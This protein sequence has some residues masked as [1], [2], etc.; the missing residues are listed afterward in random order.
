MNRDDGTGVDRR[1]MGAQY[2]LY[3]GVMGI[4]LPYFNLYCFHLGFS[5]L[6]IGILSATRS[7]MMILFPVFWGTLADRFQV[8]KPLYILLNFVSTAIWAALLLTTGF[9]GIL[10]TMIAYGIFYS[11]LIAFME[12]FTMEV[13]G[14]EKKR[15][16]MVRAWG[17]LAFIGVAT[18]LGRL[19]DIWSVDIIIGL[20]LAGSAVQA[21]VAL[22]IPRV[23]RHQESRFGSDTRFLRERGMCLFLFCAFLMLVSHG[24]YY[25]FLSIH[26]ESLGY[27]K[28]FIGIAWALASAAEIVVMVGSDKIFR[29]VSPENALFFAFMMATLRWLILFLATSPAM[30]LVSQMFHA[31]TYAVFHIASI[32]YVDRMTPRAA[33]T[34]GQAVN[35]ALTYGLGMT[36]G[37]FL[38]G[39]LYESLGAFRLFFISSLIA[40]GGGILFWYGQRYQARHI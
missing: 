16:G 38:N 8:R 3:F 40:L 19:I 30:I 4:M 25:G 37:L 7:L 9:C 23:R 28:T 13:L 15:Y 24:T 34:L 2:F 36:V 6:Q 32:L 18:A 11:P 27:D 1:I 22:K 12:T 14:R 5:G 20:V 29:R 17:T 33:K 35:N 26:L 31:A 10:L 39:C 21:I